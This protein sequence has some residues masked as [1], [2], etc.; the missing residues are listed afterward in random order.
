MKKIKEK[1]PQS[2]F[3]AIDNEIKILSSYPTS[4]DF[5]ESSICARIKALKN[6]RYKLGDKKVK[7]KKK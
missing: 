5:L 2:V 3:D 6:L 7:T 4:C 1:I